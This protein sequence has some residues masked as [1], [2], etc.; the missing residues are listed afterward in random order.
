MLKK[1]RKYI[2]LYL[3]FGFKECVDCSYFDK[4]NR[5]PFLH[6]FEEECNYGKVN[7]R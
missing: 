6:R 3:Q 4:C 7:G 5:K 1:I 2:Y